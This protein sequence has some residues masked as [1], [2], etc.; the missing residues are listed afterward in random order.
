M[1]GT[2]K[3]VVAFGAHPDDVEFGCGETLLLLKEQG[4]R[5]I[6][7]D[8]TKGEKAKYGVNMKLEEAEKA[9]QILDVE[10]KILDLG[11]KN[12]SLSEEHKNQVREIIEEYNPYLVFATHF[13]DVHPDNS[14]TAKLVSEFFPTIH[15]FISNVEGENYGVDVTNVYKKKLEALYKHKSQI[16]PGD[17]DWI[18]NRHKENGKRLDVG[19]GELF[20]I[21]K[22][23]GLPDIFKKLN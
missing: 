5:I 20:Y 23:I 14:N 17:M 7:V 11:D 13:K 19:K 18:D 2:N 6:L 12:I 15:Y 3:T 16:R 21:E 9:R 10:R 22:E 1:N 8:L 4:Y